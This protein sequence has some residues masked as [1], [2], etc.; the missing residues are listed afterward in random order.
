MR[1][2]TI[3][4]LLIFLLGIINIIPSFGAVKGGIEYS[5]PVDYSKLS[6]QELQDKAKNYF[7]NAQMNN[8]GEINEDITN[9]LFLYGI[10][11]NVNPE[12]QDYCIKMGILYDKI[13]KDR[14]AKGNF[15]RAIGIDSSKPEAYF[16]L[17]EYYYERTLYRRALKYYNEA[18]KLGYSYNYDLLYRMGDIYEKL[19]D[20]RSSLKYFQEASDK[21]PNQELDE[22]INKLNA[23]NESNELYNR[24]TRIRGLQ[25]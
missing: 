22:R 23:L 19:G 7:H 1:Q 16:Y 13:G 6:E 24:D 8:T 5:I 18:Y 12:N 20:T 17:G 14:Y 15:A 25:E 11:Q 21:N 2:F 4:I 9:A 3:T 10:L